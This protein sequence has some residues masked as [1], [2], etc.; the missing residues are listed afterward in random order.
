MEYDSTADSLKHI[1]RVQELLI[2]AAEYILDRGMV[3]D[4]SKLR[5]PEKECFD[6]ITPLLKKSVYGSP[7]YRAVMEEFKPAL[8]HH[9]SCNPHHPEFHPH[10]LS[11]FNL[12]DLIEMF[13]DWKAASERHES[14]DIFK[15]IEIN[16]KRFGMSDQ[17]VEI[18]KNT[19][20]ELESRNWMR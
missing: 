8:D 19:A 3:H 9:Y 2:I 7:E 20:L 15:S 18:L 11:D 12:F 17:L 10:G 13:F 14:G 16:Q 5:S 1:K 6:Q 4:L